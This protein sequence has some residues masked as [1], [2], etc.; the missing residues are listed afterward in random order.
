MEPADPA[1]LQLKLGQQDAMLECQQQQL[2]AVM[3]CVQTMT[4]QMGKSFYRGPGGT[5]KPWSLDCL[6]SCTHRFGFSAHLPG[7]SGVAAGYH[8][9]PP[10][11]YPPPHLPRMVNMGPRRRPW[12]WIGPSS[13]RRNGRDGSGNEPVFTAGGLDSSPQIVQ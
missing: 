8:L 1:Q 4:H 7:T 5:P 6:C 3:Q 11:I 13:L 12:W 10:P 2:L 9:L